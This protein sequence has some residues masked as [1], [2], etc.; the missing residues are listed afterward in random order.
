MD[1]HIYAIYIMYAYA[2][3]HARMITKN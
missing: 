1:V 2:P 3:R